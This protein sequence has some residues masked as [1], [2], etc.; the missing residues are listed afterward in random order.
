MVDAYLL[1]LHFLAVAVVY[2]RDSG[3]LCMREKRM[4]GQ[5]RCQERREIESEKTCTQKKIVL[6]FVR[7]LGIEETV[8]AKRSN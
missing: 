7:K 2:G 1:W 5:R 8:R 6:V 4:G 3:D